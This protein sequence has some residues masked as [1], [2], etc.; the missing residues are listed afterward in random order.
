MARR[1]PRRLSS[2]GLHEF[3]LIADIARRFGTTDRSV[4]RGIGDDA[5]ILRPSPKDLL[6]LTTDLLAEGVHFDLAT[7]TFEDVGYKAA[8]ANLS[9]IAA[10]GGSPRYCLVSLAIPHGRTANDIGRLY[11]GLMHACRPYDVALIGG[12]TSASKQGLFINVTLVGSVAPGR[13]LTRDGAKVGDWLYVTGTLGDSLAGLRL[14][15]RNGRRHAKTLNAATRRE[16]I[17]RHLRPSPRLALGQALAKRNLATSAIDLSDGLSGD[18]AHICEQSRVGASVDLLRLPLSPA[19]L[20]YAEST[21]ADPFRLALAGGEDY[22]L[23]FTAPPRHK[24]QVERLARRLGCRLSRIGTIHAPR[25]GLTLIEPN[26]SSHKLPI[27]SY[28]HFDSAPRA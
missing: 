9:D 16:L 20:D 12:D 18:L 15:D 7:A 13:A 24:A 2:S 10:M 5:A 3:P 6:L 22:E 1:S 19:C 21:R 14:L 27:I 4:L 25:L 23:L 8:V 26:G 28:R 17:A 11:R